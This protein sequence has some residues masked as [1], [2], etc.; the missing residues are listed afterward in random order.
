MGTAAANAWAAG[1]FRDH[2]QDGAASGLSWSTLLHADSTT[3]RP[4]CSG[5]TRHW[6]SDALDSDPDLAMAEDALAGLFIALT[7]S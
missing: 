5:S 1:P 4:S 2:W 3:T 7:F 6:Q